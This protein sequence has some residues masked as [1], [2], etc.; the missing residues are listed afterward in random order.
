M[1]R[2]QQLCRKNLAGLNDSDNSS[3]VKKWI[4][5]CVKVDMQKSDSRIRK[6]GGF[7]GPPVFCE[8]IGYWVQKLRS[9][10]PEK[11]P[12]TLVHRVWYRQGIRKDSV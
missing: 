2:K 3:Y 1:T 8:F 5:K 7:E 6:K 12:K 11:I 10:I 4:C 9:K